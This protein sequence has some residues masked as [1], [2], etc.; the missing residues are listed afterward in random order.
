[1]AF[2]NFDNFAFMNDGISTAITVTI[3]GQNNGQR[4]E[5][6]MPITTDDKVLKVTE[7]IVNTTNPN[8]NTNATIGGQLPVGTLYWLSTMLD[9]P[10]HTKVVIDEQPNVTYEVFNHA[11]D[12]M[13]GRRYYELK[14]VGTDEQIG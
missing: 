11:D 3:P 2:C 8:L 9:I 1:M 14:E 13:A 10:L 5:H 4:D 12:I 7:P 6:G